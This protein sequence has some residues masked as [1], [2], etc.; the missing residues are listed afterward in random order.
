LEAGDSDVAHSSAIET[1]SLVVSPWISEFK[2]K[3]ERP[4]SA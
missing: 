2:R 1:P 3:V 4:S